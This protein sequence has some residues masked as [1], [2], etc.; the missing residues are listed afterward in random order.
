MLS[1]DF[2]GKVELTQA[3]LGLAPCDFDWVG[4]NR[5]NICDAM[6]IPRHG[7]SFP[8]FEFFVG[9]GNHLAS[10]TLVLY[11]GVAVCKALPLLPELIRRHLDRACNAHQFLEIIAAHDALLVAS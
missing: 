3:I 8:S 10:D 2:D 7:I 11:V 9:L 4:Q 1:N 5:R 6:S